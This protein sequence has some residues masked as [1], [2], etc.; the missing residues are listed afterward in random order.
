MDEEQANVSWSSDQAQVPG[1]PHAVEAELRVKEIERALES[2]ESQLGEIFRLLRQGHTPLDIQRLQDVPTVGYVY[3]YQ[4]SIRVLLG[5][6]DAFPD[7]PSVAKQVAQ[8]FRRILKRNAFSEPTKIWLDD[9]LQQ[10]DT[11][12]SDERA[13][14][15]ET[16]RALAATRRAENELQS[17]AGVSPGSPRA[18]VLYVYSL[19]HYLRYRVHEESGRTYL[20]IGQT[21]R[22]PSLRISEQA[23]Q[24]GLPE[25]PVLLRIY[26]DSDSSRSIG[27]LE[28]S[29][30]T[31][32]EAA[33]HDRSRARAG[34][35]EWFVTSLKFLDAVASALKLTIE[36]VSELGD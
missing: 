3:A 12:L 20:K 28:R 1:S 23:R 33:D 11:I 16:E 30:H 2:D 24:T 22:D 31:L 29:V 6:P 13:V 9:R 36:E 34:G 5:E 10:L 17:S 27:D 25:D 14:E 26:R 18:G 32:L 35:R 15:D 4:R 7:K 21:V 8:A 19:P